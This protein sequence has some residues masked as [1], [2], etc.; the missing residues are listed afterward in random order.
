M[1]SINKRYF[2]SYHLKEIRSVEELHS[3]AF[4]DINLSYKK[5]TTIWREKHF[6]SRYPLIYQWYCEAKINWHS[7]SLSERY[8]YRLGIV[9]ESRFDYYLI[10]YIEGFL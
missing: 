4:I 5:K 6:I 9:L 3:V 10:K 2:W 8:K 1:N 7:I